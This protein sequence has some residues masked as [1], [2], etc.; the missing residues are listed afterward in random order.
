MPIGDDGL[1]AHPYVATLS[2]TLPTAKL[3]ED[4][5]GLMGVEATHPRPLACG[6]L[7]HSLSADV[8]THLVTSSHSEGT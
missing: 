2:H 5:G 6:S 3:L 4:T 1:C 7:L 8:P